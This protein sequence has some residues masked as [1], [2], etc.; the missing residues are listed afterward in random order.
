MDL[1]GLLSG[2]GQLGTALLPYELS[3]SEIDKLSALGANLG[4][5]ATEIGK[6]AADATA[7]QPF[8]VKTGTATTGVGADGGYDMQLSPELKAL[9]DQLIGQ[10][11]T[12]A[13]TGAMDAQGLF[14]LTQQMRSPEI[15]RQR[16]A[17]ESRLAAQGRL[18]T[19]TSMFGG[20]PEA[21][22]M[23]K[24]LAEQQ[25][26]DLFQAQQL[27]PA[28]EAARIGNI[29]GMLG[30][31][32][33]PE[34]Q[35]LAALMPGIDISRIGQAARQGESEA[36][37]RAGIAGLEAEAAT[38]TAAANIEAARSQALANA[39]SG[40][41]AKPDGGGSSAGQDF[42]NALFGSSGSSNTTNTSSLSDDEFFNTYGYF[43]G[44][45]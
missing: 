10:A 45:A 36:L 31:A 43:R 1:A 16:L 19:Q 12:I 25:S 33:S 28:L 23:E 44:E 34:N 37:Y 29:T 40:M 2:A 6:T 15:E 7:F 22:A 3:Q 32:F 17:M 27:A 42:F 30:A 39:L 41:F 8:T 11:G 5:R 38:G 24:A 21:L 18:G 14:D 9:Q 13:G 35:A 26:A 20:T 4:T